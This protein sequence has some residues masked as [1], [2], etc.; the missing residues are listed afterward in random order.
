MLNGLFDAME[1]VG[2][3]DNK[4]LRLYHAEEKFQLEETQPD[5]GEQSLEVFLPATEKN[6]AVTLY[7]VESDGV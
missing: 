2:I 1:A 4:L 3:G 5:E 6:L 7:N